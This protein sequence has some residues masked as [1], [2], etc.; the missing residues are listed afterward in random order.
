MIFGILITKKLLECRAQAQ[1]IHIKMDVAQKGGMHFD[2]KKLYFVLD[3]DY[4]ID[5]VDEF[6]MVD[7]KATL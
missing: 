4:V 5:D 7:T 6:F 3:E 1:E 2:G